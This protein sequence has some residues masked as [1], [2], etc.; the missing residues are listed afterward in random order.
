VDECSLCGPLEGELWTSPF[1]R[2]VLNRNQNLLG[3]TM[4]VLRRHATEVVDLSPDEWIDLHEQ[5]RETASRIEAAFAPE[6]FNY[7]FLQNVDR[8]MHLHVI[9]RYSST[10]GVGGERF[11]DPDFPN[12][13][14]VP[15]PER[16]PSDR[17]MTAIITALSR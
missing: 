1:W 5:M 7:A 4:L 2:A 14:S 8:H 10:R 3:K 15:A 16:S 9:P 13:Y 12:H 17:T 6:R 11:D